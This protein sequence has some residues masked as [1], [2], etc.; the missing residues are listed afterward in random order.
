MVK[1]LFE[2]ATTYTTNQIQEY[3]QIM[4]NTT[5]YFY[6]LFENLI[7]WAKAQTGKITIIPENTSM[8]RL[9]SITLPLVS[10]SA[11]KK[12]SQSNVMSARTI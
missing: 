8:D 3:A 7:H 4:N 1:L 6:T 11:L 9:L 5:K 12:I 2:N 10:G